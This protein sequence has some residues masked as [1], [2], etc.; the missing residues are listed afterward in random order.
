MSEPSLMDNPTKAKLDSDLYAAETET[1]SGSKFTEGTSEEDLCSI[2]N[3]W[4]KE[5]R[6]YHDVLKQ[7]QDE[8][9]EYYKGNQTDVAEIAAFNSNSVYNRIYEATETIIPAVTGSAQQFIAIPGEE[10]ELSAKR[11]LKVQ[12]VLS[13][14][15]DDLEIMR[16][17]ENSTRDIILKRYGVLKPFWH[18]RY[19]QMSSILL[20]SLEYKFEGLEVGTYH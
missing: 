14:K 12:K 17:L 1:K 8:M 7:K 10:N 11:A 18:Y 16:H 2:I 6:S 13:R 19:K 9:V 20:P 4:V 5:S 15:Y 3:G